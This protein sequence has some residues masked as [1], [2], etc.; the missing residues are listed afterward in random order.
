MH[1]HVKQVCFSLECSA[2]LVTGVMICVSIQQLRPLHS[3]HKNQKT[4]TQNR[5]FTQFKGDMR[6]FFLVK[7]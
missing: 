2:V 1:N 7:H 3:K 6:D 4:G 5:S